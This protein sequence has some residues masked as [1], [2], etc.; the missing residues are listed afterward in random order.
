[1]DVTAYRINYVDHEG[2]MRSIV[3]PPRFRLSYAVGETTE[4]EKGYIFS[5]ANIL[6][7]IRFMFDFRR[8]ALCRVTG[9]LAGIIAAWQ[10]PDPDLLYA[11]SDLA[12]Q[13]LA[14]AIVEDGEGRT[15]YTML[16]WCTTEEILAFKDSDDRVTVTAK[17]LDDLALSVATYQKHIRGVVDVVDTIEFTAIGGLRHRVPE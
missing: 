2:H 10:A 6:E 11:Y 15:Y 16:D 8:A 12:F 14:D 7:A 9:N 1:M 3:V 13:K 4:P 5:H 17:H